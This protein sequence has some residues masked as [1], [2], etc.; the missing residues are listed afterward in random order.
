MKKEVKEKKCNKCGNV[1]PIDDFPKGRGAVCKVCKRPIWNAKSKKSFARPE[2]KEKAKKY[3]AENEERMKQKRKER[4]AKNHDRNL[5]W[6]REYEKKNKEKRQKQRRERYANNPD[7]RLSHKLSCNI[8]RAV[9]NKWEKAYKTLETLGCSMIELREHISK[10]FEP[11][12]S[13]ENYSYEIWHLDHIIPKSA[14]DLGDPVMQKICFGY[15]NLRPMWSK[16]NMQKN[17]NYSKDD[18]DIVL[19]KMLNAGVIKDLSHLIEIKT[20]ILNYSGH[21]ATLK[22]TINDNET[23]YRVRRESAQGAEVS[24]RKDRVFAGEQGRQEDV[25]VSA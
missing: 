8:K 10:M 23:E 11:G 22:Q 14:F 19:D 16:H 6:Q 12:M 2:K 25:R 7:A 21:N 4:D 9:K 24:P 17:K 18:L 15:L 5:Q 1:K 20:S 3:Y 13:W